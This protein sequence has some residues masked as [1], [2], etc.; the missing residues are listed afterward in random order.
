MV[1]NRLEDNTDTINTL[2][3]YNKKL[4]W[5]GMFIKYNIKNGT[6]LINKL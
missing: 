2:W 3:W 4:M 5:Y 6:D 1:L